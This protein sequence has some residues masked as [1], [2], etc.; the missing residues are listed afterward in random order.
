MTT[1]T[2]TLAELAGLAYGQFE[3]RTRD[4]DSAYVTLRDDAPEWL[5]D[6][7]HE[8]HGDLLPDDWRYES[9][10]SALSH[11]HDCDYAD[12]DEA[13]DGA[14]EFADG[15]VDTYNG[16]RVEWLGSHLARG[17]YCDEAAEELGW[18]PS[19]GIYG[20][21]GLGQ[22]RESEEIYFSVVGS[23][24]ERLDELAEEE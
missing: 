4:D 2:N 11:I 18:D 20:L 8:A 14:S 3:R 12:A 19:A 17:G 24:G 1:T 13:H 21:I 7:V 15:N 6:L 10:R 5:G 22:Y 9:I 16:A 23:L